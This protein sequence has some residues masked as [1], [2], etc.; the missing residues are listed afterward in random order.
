MYCVNLWPWHQEAWV[1]LEYTMNMHLADIFYLFRESPPSIFPIYFRYIYFVVHFTNSHWWHNQFQYLTYQKK[2]IIPSSRNIFV[3]MSYLLWALGR[4][5]YIF[6]KLN[7][8]FYCKT[9]TITENIGI[10][11]SALSPSWPL[12]QGSCSLSEKK[13][14]GLSVTFRGEKYSFLRDLVWN[15][16]SFSKNFCNSMHKKTIMQLPEASGSQ[17][18]KLFQCIHN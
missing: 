7:S 11:V 10:E 1:S 8:Q 4:I 18:A 9:K 12:F 5:W 17:L 6:H 14:P 13:N 2:C 16:L 3:I 15:I